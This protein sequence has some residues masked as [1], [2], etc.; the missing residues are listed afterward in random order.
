MPTKKEINRQKRRMWQLLMS[1]DNEVSYCV[2]TYGSAFV[3]DATDGKKSQLVTVG[4]PS[5][6]NDNTLIKLG[7]NPQTTTVKFLWLLQAITILSIGTKGDNTMKDFTY[8]SE[9]EIIKLACERLV[10]IIDV[11][12]DRNA[13]YENVVGESS[14]RYDRLISILNKKYSELHNYIMDSKGDKHNA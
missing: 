11:C 2:K 3:Y 5:Q 14:K 6:I 4:R 1:A 10:D 9:K 13:E 8:I 7:F 12:E